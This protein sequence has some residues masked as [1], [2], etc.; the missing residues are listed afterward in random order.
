MKRTKNFDGKKFSYYH[1]V[2]YKG[3]ANA[4]A[5][6]LRLKGFYARITG[7][8]SAYGEYSIWIRKK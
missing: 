5:R 7:P 4:I 2:Q 6:S 3:D 8:I 1:E